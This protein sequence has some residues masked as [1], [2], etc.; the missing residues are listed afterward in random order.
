ML[1]TIF[2][3]LW[4]GLGFPLGVSFSAYDSCDGD[5]GLLALPFVNI[6]DTCFGSCTSY[7]N[8]FCIA[9]ISDE[10]RIDLIFVIFSGLG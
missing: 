2:D 8:I 3:R 7:A 4:C 6:G 5:G 1:G 9:Q 10:S